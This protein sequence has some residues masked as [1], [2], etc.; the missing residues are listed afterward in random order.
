MN[1]EQD[2]FLTRDL[3]ANTEACEL[4]GLVR[5]W[6]ATATPN[7][8][9]HPL[10]FHVVLLQKSDKEEW[11]FHAWPRGSR[12]ITGIPAPIHT[13]NKVVESKVLSGELSN[14]IYSVMEAESGAPVYEV[15]Y[16]GDRYIPGST[17]VLVR[18]SCCVQPTAISRQLVQ[19]NE[20][21]AIPAHIFHQ[22]D[23]AE[24]ISA[25][26]LVCMHSPVPGSIKIIGF[27]GYPDRIEFERPQCLAVEAANFIK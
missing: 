16:L 5:E 26:T 7:C 27:D 20:S 3:V 25:A 15:E 10:G 6:I 23:V 21:Y 22:T 9:V 4:L 13:H 17:N 11:R 19:V 24:S 2:I 14:V 12:R 8:L 1:H 18:S